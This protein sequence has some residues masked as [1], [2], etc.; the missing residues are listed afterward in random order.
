MTLIRK[1]ALK[2]SDAVV[3]YASPGCKEWAEGLAREVAFVEGDWSA[4]GWAFGSVR[5]LFDYREAP[6]ESLADLP[7]AAERFAESKRNKRN[8]TW[9]IMFTDG[10][11]YCDKFFRATNWS[12][13][14]GCSLVILGSIFAGMA[15]LLQ[16]RSRLKVPPDDDI[17]ALV[18]FYGSELERTYNLRS[19][20]WRIAGSGFTLFCVGAAMADGV[21][22]HPIWDMAWGLLW[23]GGLLLF[24]QMR[25]INQ[26]RIERLHT[27]LA[28]RS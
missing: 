25:R 10:L 23:A 28:E 18:Q 24:L 13:R 9:I 1:L 2:I 16:W 27:L 20:L 15:V 4:L 5:V 19:S 12:E 3:D 6:V 26:R 8:A 14:A 21:R 22:A 11:I 7:A 17:V